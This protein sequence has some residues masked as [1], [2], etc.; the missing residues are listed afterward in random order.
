MISEDIL[1][2]KFYVFN[3]PSKFCI[4]LTDVKQIYENDQDELKLD[5]VMINF[6][7]KYNFHIS[8]FV[9]FIAWIVQAVESFIN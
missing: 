3:N 6:V 2:T 1:W 9:S 8:A 7:Y 4:F 5:R